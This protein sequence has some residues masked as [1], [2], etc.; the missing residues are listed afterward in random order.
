MHHNKSQTHHN[1][2]S[3]HA[4]QKLALILLIEMLLIFLVKNKGATGR[5]ASATLSLKC[6]W[7]KKN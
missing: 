2:P 6:N 3:H 4:P 1:P 7:K 5:E